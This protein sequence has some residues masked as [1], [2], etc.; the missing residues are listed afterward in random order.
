M[1]KENIFLES[2]EIFQNNTCLPHSHY[3]IFTTKE[4]ALSGDLQVSL[5][6]GEWKFCYKNNPY[7]TIDNCFWDSSSLC[8][9]WNSI[10]VP[11]HI[12][13]SGY[14]P[15]QYV[16]VSY[17]WDGLEEVR[18]GSVPNKYNPTGYYVTSF[19]FKERANPSRTFLRFD[20]VESC[21]FLWI[22]G[23]FVG[24][25]ED[26]FTPAEFDISSFILPGLNKIAVKVVKWC[27]GSWLEDQDFWRL[28]GIFRD[29]TLIT[30]PESYI[31]D[32]TVRYSCD[33]KHR[34][35]SVVIE[36]QTNAAILPH[37][38]LY[39][40]GKVLPLYDY[41]I[42]KSR[43]NCY[44]ISFRLCEVI[45]W[46][47]ETPHLY[48]LLLGLENDEEYLSINLGFR[49][50]LIENGILKINGRRLIINGINRHEFSAYSGRAIS[51]QDML[52]DVKTMKQNNINAVR[53]SHYPN[54]PDFYELCNLYGLY[55]LD[56]VNLE[57]QGTWNF[58][59]GNSGQKAIP[60]NS[61]I[62][63]DNVLNRAA[64]LYHRDK[65]FTCVIIWSLGNESYG[66]SNFLAMKDYF[67]NQDPSR[68]VHYE[69][70]IFEPAYSDATD[71][72][73]TMYYDTEQVLN[74]LDNNPGKPYIQCEFSHAMG[75]SCGILYKY[76]D[77]VHKYSHYQGGFLWDFI[78]QAIWEPTLK[79][80]LYGGD[81]KERPND[82][83][84]CGNG[85][86]FADRRISPKMQE[87]KYCYQ[88][89]TICINEV[90]CIIFNHMLFTNTDEYQWV[91]TLFEN[92][93]LIQEKDIAVSCPPSESVIYPHCFNN[94]AP[95]REYTMRLSMQLS[96]DILWEGQ[97]YELGFGEFISGKYTAPNTDISASRLQY[98]DSD[99]YFG[100]HGN[101]FSVLFQKKT[102]FLVSYR[103]KGLELIKSP[104][105]P[106]FWRAPT[107]NDLGFGM[108][109]LCGKWKLAGPYAKL[110]HFSSCQ[111]EVYIKATAVYSIP[112]FP[113]ASCRLTYKVYADGEI[114]I[115]CE[116]Y[117]GE[118]VP[119]MLP[120]FSILFTTYSE[121]TE[122]SY[123]GLGPDENYC[124][125][126]RGAK[127]GIYKS[128]PVSNC[129]PYLRPQ[130]CGMR[131]GI[132][133]SELLNKD[134]EGMRFDFK[135]PLSVSIL[136]YT[137]DELENA[138]HFF[139]LPPIYQTVIRIAGQHMGIGGDDS[140]GAV[141]HSEYQIPSDRP[142]SFEF[143]L[144]GINK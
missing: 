139:E 127:L 84:F 3:R 101:Y 51:Y 96:K 93:V 1:P 107:D 32:F 52:W 7:L 109:S 29:V 43:T 74:Y 114:N 91:L 77:L 33:I 4:S 12:E 110:V 89:V 15:P 138:G 18:I 39:N 144:K 69:G 73:S 23:N 76:T 117:P 21:L 103:Y 8:E 50:I 22:N 94:L 30:R 41:N 17:P 85:I 13:L 49:E 19:L 106:N 72:H 20:G 97:G 87:V 67:H 25:S 126:S 2:P 137:P 68:P 40:Q 133:Y 99:Y 37:A 6:N 46:S 131:T 143:L 36:V 82:G 95:D 81:F 115:V 71:I 38:Q 35:C 61:E 42:Q 136:P 59:D 47:S 45:F 86:V 56:E 54:H 28:S 88:P 55:V 120:E 83:N 104:I 102:G 57:T 64:S 65:N 121:F 122:W 135:H 100:I 11:S 134:S 98:V 34:L 26:S 79:A 27:S 16:N 113:E 129:T 118:A 44:H 142:Y 125:R 123:Y 92:G 128:D 80:L 140:W 119:P 60:H 116:Y 9:H 141:P 66:G 75:N 53:T 132:R 90:N 70:I 112:V 105:R 130:E 58:P 78:D 108:D 5:L 111:E 124:D 31:Q 62:W 14:A 10:I 24:Y 63:K 48:Q